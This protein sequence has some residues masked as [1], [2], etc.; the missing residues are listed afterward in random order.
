MVQ[1]LQKSL[2]VSCEVKDT[3]AKWPSS[4]TTKGIKNICAHQELCESVISRFF[5][6]SFFGV[7]ACRI[8]FPQSRNG[9]CVPYFGKSLNRWAVREVQLLA[10]LF[11]MTIPLLGIYPREMKMYVCVYIYIY[12][13][14]LLQRVAMGLAMPVIKELTEPEVW[15]ESEIC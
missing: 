2:V 14:T 3:F 11:T 5:F 4:F 15:V 8:L 1:L 13:H 6:S 7:G 12:I 9:S 10:D